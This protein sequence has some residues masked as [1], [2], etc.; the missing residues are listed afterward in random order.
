MTTCPCCGQQVAAAPDLATLAADAME[1]RDRLRH[2][3][4]A[5]VER[6]E[7][8][9]AQVRIGR[10]VEIDNAKKILNGDDQ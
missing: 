8:A 1:E 4:L 2:A 7:A 9:A 3:L 10:W 5:L 6:C